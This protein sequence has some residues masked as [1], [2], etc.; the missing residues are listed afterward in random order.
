MGHI[1]VYHTNSTNYTCVGVLRISSHYMHDYLKPVFEYLK[2]KYPSINQ[3]TKV[4]HGCSLQYSWHFVCV[5]LEKLTKPVGLL[6][7]S[8]ILADHGSC[9]IWFRL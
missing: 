5:A 3:G 2:G 6:P 7:Q 1:A 4:Q 9:I 8:M